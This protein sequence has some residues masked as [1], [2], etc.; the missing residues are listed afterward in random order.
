VDSI[1]NVDRISLSGRLIYYFA[2]LFITQWPE[3]TAKYPRAQFAGA[4]L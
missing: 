1:A 3:L 2:D 4:I